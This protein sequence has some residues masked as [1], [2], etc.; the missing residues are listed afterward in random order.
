MK[1]EDVMSVSDTTIRQVNALEE[2]KNNVI[3]SDDNGEFTA[4]RLTLLEDASHRQLEVLEDLVTAVQ[5]LDTDRAST[6]GPLRRQRIDIYFRLLEGRSP[7]R[8]SDIDLVRPLICRNVTVDALRD[9]IVIL[10]HLALE[11]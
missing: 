5:R 4:E 6:D 11:E 1:E 9:R 7:F 8:S 2:L 3:N 10:Q